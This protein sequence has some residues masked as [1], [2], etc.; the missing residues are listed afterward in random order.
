MGE[1]EGERRVESFKRCV[2]GV[3][4]G[5]GEFQRNDRVAMLRQIGRLQLMR[6]KSR[7]CLGGCK[8]FR[9]GW[10]MCEAVSEYGGL[11]RIEAVYMIRL[12]VLYVLRRREACACRVQS[13][14]C[15]TDQLPTRHG[16]E[17]EKVTPKAIASSCVVAPLP[18]KYLPHQ[19]LHTFLTASSTTTTH[20][21][22]RTHTHIHTQ[23]PPNSPHHKAN[24]GKVCALSASNL[25]FFF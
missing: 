9:D 12:I 20:A 22:T 4:A 2:F 6:R 7:V 17:T 16:A 8:P 13:Q 24:Q 19:N 11:V 3:G 15:A 5:A 18:I 25:P 23:W 14:F 1:E 21:R 10:E